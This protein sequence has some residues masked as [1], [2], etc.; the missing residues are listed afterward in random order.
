MLKFNTADF[1]KDMNN[2]IRYT[3]GFVEGAQKGK[4]VAIAKIGFAVVE[5]LKQFID[6]NARVNP[7]ALHHVYEWYQAGSPEARL[8]DIDYVVNGLGLSISSTFRQ[9]VVAKNGNTPF[10]DKARIMEQGLPVTITPRKSEVLAFEDNG[11]QVF[12]KNPVR[13]QNP[14]GEEVRGSFERTF[15]MFINQYFTQAF[16]SSSGIL[17]SLS[18]AS[19]Y[20]NSL[21]SGLKSGKA[22]GI[23]AGYKW[24]TKVGENA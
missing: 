24:I 3:E 8:F 22:A 21:Q 11:E 5:S 16:L 23:A 9:S 15:D 2:L 6:A 18:N 14:G 17:G 19:E 20:K 1:N 4:P 13:V 7:Q 10:Y 12:T